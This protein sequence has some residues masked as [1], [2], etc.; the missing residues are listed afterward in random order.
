MS[1]VRI[2]PITKCTECPF[3]TFDGDEEFQWGK[4]WCDKLDR[5]VNSDIPDDCPLPTVESLLGK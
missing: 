5:E 3:H 2:A 4:L 1:K